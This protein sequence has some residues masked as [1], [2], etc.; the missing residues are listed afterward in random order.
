MSSSKEWTTKSQPP[1][2]QQKPLNSE[3]QKPIRYYLNHQLYNLFIPY[4]CEEQE[5][6]GDN[7]GTDRNRPKTDKIMAKT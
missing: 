4:Q 3:K 1:N 6:F 5:E 2:S 7:K